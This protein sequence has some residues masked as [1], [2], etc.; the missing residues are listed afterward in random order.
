MNEAKYYQYVFENVIKYTSKWLTEEVQQLTIE[1]KQNTLNL[2]LR[3]K[4]NIAEFIYFTAGDYGANLVMENG[5]TSFTS[6]ILKHKI[7]L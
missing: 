2:Q 7:E 4:R 3:K 1:T 5:D 6:W